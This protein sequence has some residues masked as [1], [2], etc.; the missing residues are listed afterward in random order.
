M[1]VIKAFKRLLSRLRNSEHIFFLMN[2]VNFV[3]ANLENITEIIPVWN[4]FLKQYEKED[5]I[6][7][8]STKMVE[9]KYVTEAH[10]K[11]YNA[12][13]MFRRIVEAASYSEEPDVKDA[14]T[15]LSEIL[16]NYKTVTTAAITEVSAMLYNMIED[17]HKPRY[18]CAV[19][20]LG[21][22]TAVDNIEAANNE[23]INI[24]SD[25]TQNMETF[26]EQGTMRTIRPIVDNAFKTFADGV[27]SLYAIKKIAGATDDQ[28]PALPI[29]S[30]I[31]S[32]ID[33]FERVYAHRTPGY[34]I[35]DRPD[36]DGGDGDEDG[37]TPEPVEPQIPE[38]AVSGQYVDSSMTMA[39]IMADQEAFAAA[40]YPIAAEGT[41]ILVAEP[42]LDGTHTN[43]PIWADFEMDGNTPV[44]ILVKPPEEN[45]RF[46]SPLQSF[47]QCTAEVRKDGVILAILTNVEWPVCNGL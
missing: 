29:I 39:L 28:N 21:L 20:K 18:A 25:R 5:D 11:C 16:D 3:K 13:M 43:C 44:G 38:L 47:G 36:T 9:T 34:S 46:V 7:K 6:Y 37:L 14:Y 12:F 30:Y 42:S 8:R 23:F 2:V 19:A 22:G 31:N 32:F 15:K 4:A 26:D 1:K 10:Q 24:Y 27:N 35:P 45:F 41:M 33:Q 40:L 17:L